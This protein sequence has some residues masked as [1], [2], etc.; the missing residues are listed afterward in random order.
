M[1]RLTRRGLAV[2]LL[3]ILVLP[4]QLLLPRSVAAQEQGDSGRR[5]KPVTSEQDRLEQRLQE[6][7]AA[8]DAYEKV[9]RSITREQERLEQRV[10]ELETAKT[11]QEDVTRSIIRES[12][13]TLGAK[14]NEQ[15]TLGGAL[16]VLTGWGE[17][18]SGESESV[19]RLDTAELDLEIQPND[20]TLGSIILEYNDGV[21]TLFPTTDELTANDR[22]TI[23]TA[24]VTLGDTQRFPP[25]GTFG[26]MIVPFGIST[27]DPVADVLTLEDPLTVEVFEAKED[28]I[29]LGFGFPTPALTPAPPPITPPRVRP[30]VIN[31]LISGLSRRLGFH[32]PPTRPSPP[33]LLTPT[34]APPLFSG[35]VYFF[36]GNTFDQADRGRSPSD[37]IG[38][39]LGFRTQGTCRSSY[40]GHAADR[41]Q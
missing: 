33:T 9:T 4:V 21:D 28:A 29:L 15:V 26:R 3:C 24:F 37:H 13:S 35:G 22:I 17:D 31:P 8:K 11:T 7:E 41:R 38:A 5:S 39:T 25:F 20:W 18:F 1:K 6:L 19:L 16:E 2:P 27:G 14:I 12:V 32:Q 40:Q 36:D 30:L 34:P 23:D 10:K